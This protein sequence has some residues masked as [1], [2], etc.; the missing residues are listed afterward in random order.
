MADSNEGNL[1]VVS[2][3]EPYKHVFGEGDQVRCL[4]VGGGLTTAMN[5][6]MRKASGYG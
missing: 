4:E 1:I 6:Q 3:A 5:P 2:N